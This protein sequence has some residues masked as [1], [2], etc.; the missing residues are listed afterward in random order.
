MEIVNF[1]LIEVI[2]DSLHNAWKRLEEDWYELGNVAGAKNLFASE[3]AVLKSKIIEEKQELISQFKEEIR[4]NDFDFINKLSNNLKSTYDNNTINLFL[5]QDIMKK[6][7]PTKQSIDKLIIWYKNYKNSY[8]LTNQIKTENVQYETKMNTKINNIE[9][10][11]PKIKTDLHY[12]WKKLEE[13]WYSLGN[14]KS[15]PNFSANSNSLLKT[16]R[17]EY[18]KNILDEIIDKLDKKDSLI[19]ELLTKIYK[20]KPHNIDPELNEII[21]V[22]KNFIKNAKEEALNSSIHLKTNNMK[23]T[24]EQNETKTLSGNIGSISE[25]KGTDKKYIDVSI[26]TN[27][28]GEKAE[29]TNVRV[30]EDTKGNPAEKNVGDFIKVEGYEKTLKNK[31]DEDYTVFNVT[32]ITEHKANTK[33][34][35]TGNL[36]ADPEF[37]EVAGKQV[38]TI[39]IAVKGADNVTEWKRI[40]M[41]E[42]KAEVAKG[43]KKGDTVTVEGKEG[44]EY[45]YK[46]GEDVLTTKDIVAS[47][48][49]KHEKKSKED[50]NKDL[51]TY[52]QKGDWKEVSEALKKGADS[53]IITDDHL[54]DLTTKQQDAIK[55]TIRT[56]E[57]FVLKQDEKKNSGMKM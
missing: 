8:G 29:F 10:I 43:L 13:E 38:A 44:K 31:K 18:N 4:N 28:P 53:K 24:N 54:K 22:Y 7:Y 15:V 37:K 51:I 9:N 45:T 56:H 42:D 21:I 30:W 2:D 40:Q 16:Q 34:K 12:K 35:V 36:G 46:K 52:A 48:V 47:V 11:I 3:K 14:R 32:A 20:E 27:K 33:L 55:N 19:V 23:T 26:A 5:E 57:D 49:D 1:K 17:I 50:L 39:S 41:W 25:M 6:K